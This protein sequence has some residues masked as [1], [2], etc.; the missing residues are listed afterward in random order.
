[1]IKRMRDLQPLKEQGKYSY[2]YQIKGQLK[3]E[4]ICQGKRWNILLM[5]HD[6]LE[7]HAAYPQ[8]K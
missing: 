1:M 3:E 6:D 2:I 8:E 5:I 4:I 7:D